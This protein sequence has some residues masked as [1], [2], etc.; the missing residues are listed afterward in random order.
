[1]VAAT[2]SAKIET[3]HI[4]TGSEVVDDL[5]VAAGNSRQS[6]Q[7]KHR[8]CTRRTVARLCQSHVPMVETHAASGSCSPKCYALWCPSSQEVFAVAV[9]HGESNT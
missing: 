7:Q 4:S 9:G 3:E 2:M 1:M 5:V 8:D 6:V